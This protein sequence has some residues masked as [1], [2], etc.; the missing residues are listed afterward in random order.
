MGEL[1]RLTTPSTRSK[2]EAS[3]IVFM[4]LKGTAGIAKNDQADKLSAPPG[5]VSLTAFTLK[6]SESN[7]DAENSA[8]IFGT[9]FERELFPMQTSSDLDGS[10]MFQMNL[11]VKQR[12]WIVLSQFNEGIGWEKS[13]PEQPDLDLASNSCLPKGVIRGCST[14]SNC[15]TVVARWKPEDACTVMLK[16]A[17][18]FYP[19]EE[20]FKDT[21]KYIESIRQQVEPYGFCRIV[22]PPS[23]KPPCFF[24]E[25]DMWQSS[26]FATQIQ[27]I[28]ELQNHCVKRK[29]AA[30]DDGKETKKRR[31]MRAGLDHDFGSGYTTH[32]DA[33]K[34]IGMK[35]FEFDSGPHFTLEAFQNYADY[36]KEI[37]FSLKHEVDIK[38]SPSVP[39]KQG[40][41]SEENIEGEYWRIVEKPTEE[42]EVL[43]GSSLD[44]TSFG[45]G[46]PVPPKTEKASAS[47]EYLESSWNLNNISRLPGSL[48]SFESLETSGILA[49]RLHVGMCFSSFPWKVEEHHLYALYYLHLGC[50][51]IWYGVPGQFSYKFEALMKNFLD[52][53][54]QHSVLLQKSLMQLSPVTLISEGI[55]VYRCI[56]RPQEFILILPGTYHSGFNCGFN[57][58]TSAYLAPLDW[59][60]HGQ[61]LVELYRAQQRKTLLSYDKLLLKAANE[62]VKAEW[63][64]RLKRNKASR[65]LRWKDAWGKDGILHKALKSRIK[66]EARLRRYLS[67]ASQSRKM[68][69]CFDAVDKRECSICY[70]DLYLSAATC[71]CDQS[72]YSCLLHTRNLCGCAWSEKIFLFR[73]EISELNNLAE[74]LEGRYSAMHKWAKEYLGLD[75]GCNPLSG[76]LQHSDQDSFSLAE[77]TGQNNHETKDMLTPGGNSKAVAIESLLS[78]AKVRI[79]QA[80]SFGDPEGE[81]LTLAR[82]YNSSDSSEDMGSSFS[83][84]ELG[85]KGPIVNLCFRKDRPS[86]QAHHLGR[87]VVASRGTSRNTNYKHNVMESSVAASVT[88]LSCVILPKV[89]SSS[90]PTQDII[91]ISDDEDKGRY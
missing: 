45:N 55:P 2:P 79:L 60:P 85:E 86:A 17:P 11:K 24:R 74:A 44:A 18:L 91:C 48:L 15:Q 70:Y 25:K 51:K 29:T 33:I 65:N 52:M 4:E 56:Q 43:C 46:F 6:R 22:P 42:I 16:E 20:E 66:S 57:C 7:E 61:V 3:F 80:T 81:G 78:E 49:P 83:S 67:A 1:G 89:K 19:K 50:P 28:N 77:A 88:N 13:A 71:P 36:F 9:K 40:K 84:M 73:Y 72:R 63:E 37:Y 31:I 69:K 68:G 58:S 64:V 62:A 23:W 12:P 82:A 5:F 30:V 41:P 47:T 8:D 14:C 10:E 76:S 21:L 35:S 27:R 39:Q 38:F 87:E 53:S 54:V 34:C 59:L 32:F 75:P 90:H 26:R